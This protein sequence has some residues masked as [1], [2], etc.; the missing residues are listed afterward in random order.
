[1]KQICMIGEGAWG[2][3]IATVLAA[4]G[5]QVRLWCHNQIVCDEIIRTGHNKRYLPGIALS[6]LIQPT[7]SFSQAI[8]G[9]DWIFE[10]VPVQFLRSVLQNNRAII[11][12]EV[13]KDQSWVILS[14]GIEQDSL[15]FPAQILD[16]VCGYTVKK[17]VL[18][19]P[20]F[21]KD[22]ATQQITG[23]TIAS[24][25]NV[26]V[27]ALHE[28][29]ANSFFKPHITTDMIGVQVGAAVKNVIALGIGILKGAGYTDNT[30][31]FIFTQGLHE[32]ALLVKALGGSIDTVYGLSGVGDLVLTSMG[33]LGR[34]MEVG[35]RLGSGESLQKILDDTGYIPEGINTLKS[36]NQ[37]ASKHSIE[38]PICRGFY[39]VVFGS[40][41]LSEMLARLMQS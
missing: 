12:N 36:V 24:D 41:A 23:I 35:Y 7:A 32:M 13:S 40:V 28:L 21:A 11:A 15:L 5:H 34:N 37:L 4:N 2:T 8:K 22:V 25:D 1:M 31:A 29:L 6:P 27:H 17:A 18:S 30:Q 26:I 14:K 19:G 9:A 38:L 20:S 33:A 10:A 3:A 39:D 16:D